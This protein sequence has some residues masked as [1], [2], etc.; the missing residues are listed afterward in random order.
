MLSRL[1]NTIRQ[2][3]KTK[4]WIS[5][6]LLPLSW[7]YRALAWLNRKRYACGLKPSQHASAF[8]IVVGNIIAGG[9]GKTPVT[10]ALVQALQQQGFRIG[11]I[12]RGYGRSQHLPWLEVTQTSLA[13]QVGDEPLLIHQKTQVPVFVAAKRIEAA[14]MLLKLYPQTEIIISDDGLQHWALMRDYEICVFNAAGLMNGR[15]LPAGPLRESWPRKVD[16]VMAPQE[17]I[18]EIPPLSPPQPIW[19]LERKL[20]SHARS[21]TGE[22][23]NLDSLRS[24]PFKHHGSSTTSTRPRILAV[25]AIANPQ[26]FFSMLENMA[27]ALDQKIALADHASAHQLESEVRKALSVSATT[28]TIVLCT[29]KDAVKL[30][31]LMPDIFAVA[32]ETQLPAPFIQDIVSKYKQYTSPEN[33]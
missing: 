20:S 21:A 14:Q 16:A 28:K 32:L 15:T 11:V 18:K 3:W 4:G 22:R 12:S 8:T 25:A 19:Q 9:A 7:L 26:S 33:A 2:S 30:W 17:A 10:I 5:T 24:A 27:I 6:A 13:S 1:A 31:P 23:L 29:E